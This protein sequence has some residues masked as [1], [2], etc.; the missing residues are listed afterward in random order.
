MV[1]V[2]DKS[3]EAPGHRFQLPR[4]ID[5][6]NFPR[7][8]LAIAL[9]HLEIGAVR[10]LLELLLLLPA[11]T[12]TIAHHHRRRGTAIVR[13]LTLLQL[14]LPQTVLLLSFLLPPFGATIFEPHL[15]R[16]RFDGTFKLDG[17]LCELILYSIPQS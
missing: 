15:K 8:F 5:E 7:I 6:R 11:Q 10:V 9:R 13:A 4:P 3:A 14:Q 1:A 17:N 2:V 12:Q 16:A